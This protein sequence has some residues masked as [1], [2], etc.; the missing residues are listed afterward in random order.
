MLAPPQILYKPFPPLLCSSFFPRPVQHYLTL[1]AGSTQLLTVGLPRP[2]PSCST[3]KE[4]IRAGRTS[5]EENVCVKN[6]GACWNCSALTTGCLLELIRLSTNSG[7]S[8]G[9]DSAP[10]RPEETGIDS[11]S[12][13]PACMAVLIPACREHYWTFVWYLLGVGNCEDACLSAVASLPPGSFRRLGCGFVSTHSQE[14]LCLLN[15]SLGLCL[16]GGT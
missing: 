8:A 9:I 4:L 16:H 13:G 5:F 3:V 6:T 11:E 12:S 7:G 2:A 14:A 1:V 10:I 15:F